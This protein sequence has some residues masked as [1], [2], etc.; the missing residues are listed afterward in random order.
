MLSMAGEKID[1]E[2]L[3]QIIKKVDLDGDGIISIEGKF[4][5]NRVCKIVSLQ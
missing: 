1:D 3:D 5:I 2:E 4:I